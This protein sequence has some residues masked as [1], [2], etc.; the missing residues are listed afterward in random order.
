MLH[1]V[2][3]PDYLAGIFDRREDLEHYL[4]EIPERAR[5]RFTVREVPDVSLPC[6][7]VEDSEGIRAVS[8]DELETVNAVPNTT[9][10]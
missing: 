1:L 4:V 2:L 9:N 8:S 7:L 10:R 6:F 5:D 3:C